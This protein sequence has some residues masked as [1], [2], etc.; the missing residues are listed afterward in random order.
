V[1]VF[2]PMMLGARV[3]HVLTMGADSLPPTVANFGAVNFVTGSCLFSDRVVR[4]VG[5][6]GTA[7]SCLTPSAAPIDAP[8]RRLSSSSW[9]TL[10][11]L[12]SA[13]RLPWLTADMIAMLPRG[14]PVTV[15]IDVPRVQYY[16]YLLD[17]FQRG[18]VAP[19]L[20]LQWFELV[21]ERHRQVSAL[22]EHELAAA[23]SDV[24]PGRTVPIRRADGMSALEPVVRRRVPCRTPLAAADIARMLSVRDEVWAMVIRMTRPASYRELI[25]LS[26]VVEQ[27][28][29]GITRRGEYPRL[30]IAIDNPSERRA[31]AQAR[32]IAAAAT[33][34][35]SDRGPTISLLGLHPLERAFTS[36]GTG[37]SDLYY[38]DP[39]HTFIDW[40]GREYGTAELLATLYPDRSRPAREATA[41][42]PVR[43]RLPSSPADARGRIA[44]VGTAVE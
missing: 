27:L 38:N 11:E 8:V 23:V 21:D 26:Y 30:G 28:R 32:A 31:C 13:C 29:G 39:G 1:S 42:P 41:G 5:D 40:R 24:L 22:L 18:L 4:L 43:S 36:A 20:M 17:A 12:E 37:P 10:Y 44:L 16:L 7:F 6:P 9:L 19:E 25:N 2:A 33:T 3:Y 35:G 34:P 15:T 14:M